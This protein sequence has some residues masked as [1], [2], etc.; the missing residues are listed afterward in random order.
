V[1]LS[2][3]DRSARRRALTLEDAHQ[4]DVAQAIAGRAHHLEQPGQTVAGHAHFDSDCLGELVAGQPGGFL[5]GAYHL[6]PPHDHPRKLGQC[7]HGRKTNGRRP[8]TGDGRDRVELT[9]CTAGDTDRCWRP[10]DATQPPLAPA[11]PDTEAEASTDT[12]TDASTLVT[13]LAAAASWPATQVA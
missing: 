10:A 6:R 12:L 11:A 2:H 1:K 3:R 13:M 9:R 4:P 8:C 5:L 7:S